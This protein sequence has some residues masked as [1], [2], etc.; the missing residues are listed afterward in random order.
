ML[1]PSPIRRID[2]FEAFPEII[3][4]EST[5]HGGVSSMPYA[6]LNL[7]I[8]TADNPANVAQNLDIVCRHLGISRDQMASSHQVHDN[9]VL[10]VESP[11]HF[12]GYDAL[13]TNQPDLFLSVTIADCT[14]IL[15]FDPV[16]QSIAAIHAGWRGT[17]K[18]VV[19]AALQEM[20]AAFGLRPE[21]CFAYVGTCIDGSTYE[22]DEAVALHFSG[23]CKKALPDNKFL[24]DLKAA[25]EQQLLEVGVPKGQIA[26]SPYSTYLHPEHFFSHRREKGLTGRMLAVIG[27]R[28]GQ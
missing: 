3:A 17:V 16:S 18:Q 26:V 5:R 10:L 4:A 11:G 25:N 14:P 8:Y 6:S 23:A 27:R 22:V 12:E 2:H 7:G 28:R 1:H 24:V 19:R 13:V 9:K 21:Q 20:T 15:L